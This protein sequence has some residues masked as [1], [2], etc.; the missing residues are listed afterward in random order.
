LFHR[1]GPP[2]GNGKNRH[3]RLPIRKKGRRR[4]KSSQKRKEK[5]RQ[6][7]PICKTYEEETEKTGGKIIRAL[8]NKQG[9]KKN[10][11]C[12]GGNRREKTH[13]LAKG[14]KKKS[15]SALLTN[16]K[17][18]GSRLVLSIR[19]GEKGRSRKKML[20]IGIAS[21]K[22][23]RIRPGTWKLKGDGPGLCVPA[24]KEKYLWKTKKE[25]K[26]RRACTGETASLPVPVANLTI[27]PT[28][29]TRG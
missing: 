15:I 29:K 1:A 10:A 4:R 25:R 18:S 22:R 13:Q 21:P 14:G 19:E 11:A 17:G 7:T 28:G 12:P 24:G 27:H 9:E 26:G 3:T 16:F 6:S 2:R 8:Q 5:R 23:K 20:A